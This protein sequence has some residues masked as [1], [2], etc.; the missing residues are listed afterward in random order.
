MSRTITLLGA[1]LAISAVAYAELPATT[2]TPEMTFKVIPLEGVPAGTDHR[3]TPYRLF[4]K[5]IVTVWDPVS[6]GQKALDPKFS[7]DAGKLLLSYALTPAED[8]ERKCTLVS[9]FDVSNLPHRDLEV[10]FAGGPEPYTVARLRKCNFHEP[11]GEDIFE[12]LA[13]AK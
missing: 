11:R 1:G 7:I 6:C 4:D 13:P 5:M 8:S 2:G 10:H 12:C 3:V 9:E